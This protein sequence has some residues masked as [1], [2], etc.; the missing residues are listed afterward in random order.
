MGAIPGEVD[1]SHQPPMVIPLGHFVVGLV[2][3]LAGGLVGLAAAIDV[4]PGFAG[5]AHVHLFLVGFACLTI[6]GAMTQFV[7]VWSGVRLYSR[8]LAV[9]QLGLVTG[10]LG[11]FAAAL[12]PPVPT[13]LPIF[14]AVMAAG[15]WLFAYNLG[16]TL[17]RVDGLDVTERHFALALAFFVL[18]TGLGV[19]LA[20]DLV[21]PVV[22]ALPVDRPD[23]L[24]AHATLAVFG[25]ILTTVFGALYQ[26]STMFTQS[27]LHGVD[28]PLARFESAGYP[29]GV[30]LLAGG[31]FGDV[32]VAAAVGGVL[33]AASLLAFSAILGRRLYATQVDWTPML[34]R[35]AVLAA[36]MALWGALAIPAWLLD[37]L[38]PAARFGAPGTVHLLGV[39][40][41]GFVLLG[42]L[43]HIVP[44]VVWVHRYSDRLGLEPVPLIDDL[45]SDRLARTD[46]VAF[47][48]G[49]AILAAGDLLGESLAALGG[50]L[51]L[52]GSLLF[53]W[54]LAAVCWS[55]S[56][57]RGV[58]A[59]LFGPRSTT[60]GDE[61]RI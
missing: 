24:G 39:G 41:V 44:F 2:F 20:V 13:L 52:L 53:A 1:T 14:G 28:R 3:L 18:A 32:R 46:F 61:P 60:D 4:V 51:V 48:A 5:L 57:L 43:Y 36:A 29:A 21:V 55:H 15:V 16:R 37:P 34:S 54:N 10:G 38:D 25:A 35:Y 30:V 50:G 40:V 27:D 45:Y 8:R 33:V 6:M 58:L 31:R 49:G 12:L 11:G 22:D 56:H 26:L 19:L 42:T 7:P 23:V 47:L 9:A 17:V 59:H